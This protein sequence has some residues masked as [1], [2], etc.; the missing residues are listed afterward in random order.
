MTLLAI[1]QTMDPNNFDI[2]ISNQSRNDQIEQIDNFLDD[3]G[4]GQQ[5]QTDDLF[6]QMVYQSNDHAGFQPVMDY[7]LEKTV[8]QQQKNEC[9]S[10]YQSAPPPP[11]SLPPITA[12]E[13]VQRPPPSYEAIASE[14]KVSPPRIECPSQ[15]TTHVKPPKR[16]SRPSRVRSGPYEKYKDE[17]GKIRVE[18]I[19]DPTEREKVLEKREKNRIAAEKAR[20]KK[21]ERIDTLEEK[22]SDLEAMIRAADDD[23][24]KTKRYLD[25]LKVSFQEHEKV[26][27]FK[28][29]HP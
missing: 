10:A 8:K 23:Y 2:H 9:P 29:M 25:L 21:K 24:A 19:S 27:H 1:Y 22:K 11:P 14:S 18:Q 28:K 20:Y 3:L 16:T 4:S 17:S 12:A 7:Q 13:I 15:P 26:C 5:Y 6:D